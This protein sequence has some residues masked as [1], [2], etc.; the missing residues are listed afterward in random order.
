MRRW[1]LIYLTDPLIDT[2]IAA[3]C[4]QNSPYLGAVIQRFAKA[5]YLIRTTKY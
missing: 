5:G 3:S 1:P 2:A 4:Q